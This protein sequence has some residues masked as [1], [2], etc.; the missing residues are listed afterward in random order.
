MVGLG[1]ERDELLAT[2]RDLRDVGCGIL[3]IGQYSAADGRVTRR[4]SATTTP[5]SSPT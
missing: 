2:F 5:T 3:T 4:W 1:E